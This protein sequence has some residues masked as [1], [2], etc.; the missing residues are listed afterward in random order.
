MTIEQ[1]VFGLAMLGITFLA[2]MSGYARALNEQVEARKR[3]EWRD[4]MRATS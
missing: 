1:I 2:Y 4:R 3:Q